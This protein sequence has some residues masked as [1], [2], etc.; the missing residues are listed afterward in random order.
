MCH[1]T[2]ASVDHLNSGDSFKPAGRV[3]L[4]TSY[5]MCSPP[6]RLQE[7]RVLLTRR[8]DSLRQLLEE[9]NQKYEALKAALQENET[10]AQVPAAYTPLL[11]AGR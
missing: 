6:Q 10:H 1:I 2:D 5:Q 4:R 8:R 9:K 3:V 7:D 11:S